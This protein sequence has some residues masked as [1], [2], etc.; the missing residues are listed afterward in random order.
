MTW[1]QCV[2]GVVILAVIAAFPWGPLFALS[3][4]RPGYR[5]IRFSRIDVVYP[6]GS[7]L[8]P[9]YREVDRYLA[10][11][12]AFHE[13]KWQKKIQVIVCRNGSDCNRFAT[14]FL[15]RP[16]AV[17]IPT[18]TVVFVTPKVMEYRADIGELLRHELSHAVL[19]RDRSLLNILRMR[20]QPWVVEGV[21]GLVPQMATIAPGRQPIILPQ[22]EFLSPARTEELWPYF[23]D[24]VQ[25]NWR[26]SYTAYIYFWNRQI[27]RSGKDTF[28]RFE[29]ACYSDPQACRDTFRSVYG[30]ELRSAVEDFQ[31]EVQSGRVV[32]PRRIVF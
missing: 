14:P 6:S 12:Q 25:R 20:K 8:D 27:E 7:A 29:R 5:E 26:F 11:A 21:A 3:P 10:E 22:E 31:K 16:L 17:T 18:G 24:S 4:V 30:T 13:V 15:G 19:K 32:A 1:K 9:A 28:L 2:F 23:A